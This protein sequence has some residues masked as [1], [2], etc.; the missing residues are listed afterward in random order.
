MRSEY[1]LDGIKRKLLM[2][3]LAL[4]LPEFQTY[5]RTPTDRYGLSNFSDIAE[6]L[7]QDLKNSF[8]DLFAISRVEPG[9]FLTSADMSSSLML[10]IY[11]LFSHVDTSLVTVITNGSF[12]S[13]V[14]REFGDSALQGM[15]DD[16]F[17]LG[18]RP[19]FASK[20]NQLDA[21]GSALRGFARFIE[22]RYTLRYGLLDDELDVEYG[23][24]LCALGSPAICEAGNVTQFLA[25]VPVDIQKA[26][27]HS[28]HILVSFSAHSYFIVE[29][30]RPIDALHYSVDDTY[31]L[32][33]S[34]PPS[35]EHSVVLSHGTAVVSTQVEGASHD[36]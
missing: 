35:S 5:M 29:N 17:R 32:Q 14:H 28:T 4:D 8:S 31:V 6:A 23:K 12:D 11:N 9:R 36:C 19:E 7:N 15:V 3:A 1:S 34:L 24:I 16:V 27:V 20:K 26:L 2:M 13:W 18:Y 21:V 30:T 25:D 22:A 33:F 10:M